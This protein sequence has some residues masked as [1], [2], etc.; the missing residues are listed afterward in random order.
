MATLHKYSE[1]SEKSGL[2]VKHSFASRGRLFHVVYQVDSHAYSV[3]KKTGVE[4]ESPIPKELFNQ[5][6]Q[7]GHLYTNKSGTQGEELEDK[8]QYAEDEDTLE[9]LT[10][11]ARRWV[12][13]MMLNHPS[14]KIVNANIYTME[15]S[16]VNIP[17][18][19]G[20]QLLEMAKRN[21]G[22]DFFK[23]LDASY[24]NE[25]LNLKQPKRI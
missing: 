7:E 12:V 17:V 16:C 20:N 10:E 21:D 6:R 1:N 13:R 22:T 18:P 11:D 9:R 24:K 14:A 15:Y 25:R 23:N 8:L 19:Y 5:L 2:Y 4:C 3:L